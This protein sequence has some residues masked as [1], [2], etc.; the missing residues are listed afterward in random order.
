MA[1]VLFIV[2]RTSGGGAEKVITSLA[3]QIAEED[4]VWMTLNTSARPTKHIYT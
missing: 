3:S 1:N 2:P 4:Q